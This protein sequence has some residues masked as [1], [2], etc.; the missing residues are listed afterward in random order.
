MKQ[1]GFFFGIL[2]FVTAAKAQV[3]SS[4]YY[5]YPKPTTTTTIPSYYSTPSTTLPSSTVTYQSGYYKSN[6][7]YV[8]PHYKTTPNGTNL[9]NFS[10]R[11]NLNP[12]TGSTGT[13]A[14]DYSSGAYN[15]GQGKTIY[16]GPQG[17]QYYINGNGNKT[18]VP[19]RN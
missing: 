15:Y 17:G 8:E 6:G 19:K 14:R 11:S 7:T 3:S 4:S 9:D 16:T 1:L 5:N 18:Y 13:K 12:Y 10:T 2:F